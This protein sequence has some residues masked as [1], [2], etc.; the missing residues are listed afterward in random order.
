M[1]TINLFRSKKKIVMNLEMSFLRNSLEMKLFEALFYNER[2]LFKNKFFFHL[3]EI[4]N[5]EVYTSFHTYSQMLF[6]SRKCLK[7]F[8]N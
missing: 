6:F 7:Q 8:I 5:F 3:E 4:Q 2:N 1:K